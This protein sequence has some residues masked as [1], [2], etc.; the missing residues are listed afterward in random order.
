M[1]DSQLQMENTAGYVYRCETQDM[2]ESI[3]IEKKYTYANSVV[4]ICV[5]Q[6]STV[7]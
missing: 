4:Q 1:S 5:V 3:F 7:I 6:G 2:A